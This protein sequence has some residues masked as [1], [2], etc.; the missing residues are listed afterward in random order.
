MA[1][2]WL[3]IV[4]HHRCAEVP[5]PDSNMMFRRRFNRLK[6]ARKWALDNGFKDIYDKPRKFSKQVCDKDD[7]MT[8]WFVAEV[9]K[10]SEVDTSNPIAR[11]W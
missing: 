9:C 1:D 6:D 5:K 10:E 11:V 3:V 7:R 2:K 4:R 8:S